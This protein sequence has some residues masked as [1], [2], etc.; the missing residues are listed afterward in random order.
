MSSDNELKV[1]PG[2]SHEIIGTAERFI[3]DNGRVGGC[4]AANRP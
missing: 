3:E 4:G 2:Y 1:E